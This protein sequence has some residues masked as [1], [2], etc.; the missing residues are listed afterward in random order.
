MFD[1]NIRGETLRTALDTICALVE[2]CELNLNEDGITVSAVDPANVGKVEFSLSEEAFESYSAD[3]GVIGVDLVELSDYIEMAEDDDIVH[4][5]LDEESRK[6]MVEFDD[7]QY[8]LGLISLENINQ[9]G[10]IPDL[11]LPSEVTIDRSILDRGVKATKKVDKNLQLVVDAENETLS[12]KAKG[13]INEAI[14][15]I[16]EELVDISDTSASA[17]FSSNY[18]TE[19]KKAIPDGTEILLKLGDNFPVKI[20]YEISDGNGKVTYMLAPRIDNS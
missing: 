8:I 17:E 18:I 19:I 4:L 10:T 7:L 6:L 1:V 5:R 15:D 16:D 13:D 2:E 20:Q 3:G 11:D 9:S 14:F 12:M